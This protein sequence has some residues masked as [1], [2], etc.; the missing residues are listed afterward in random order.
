[1]SASMSTT[2]TTVEPPPKTLPAMTPERAIENY[3]KLREKRDAIK[4][5]H[6]DQLKPY[7]EV[8]TQLEGY[9]LG[10]L[11]TAGVQN[12]KSKTGTVY[13]SVDTSVTCNAWSKTLD[14]IRE[15]EAW[16]M[17]EARVSKTAVMAHQEEVGEIPPGVS[18]RQEIKVHVRKA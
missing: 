3:L 13:K 9:L 16:E 8:L 12:M 14:W 15:H 18:V 17:L 6:K 2:V 7:N 10:V 1:M 4:D 5:A 11:N